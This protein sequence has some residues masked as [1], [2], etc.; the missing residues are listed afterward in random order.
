MA[1]GGGSFTTENNDLPGTY[2]NFVSAVSAS[3]ALSDRGVATMPLELDWGVEGEVFEVTNEDFQKRS[4]KIFGYPVDN[5]KMKGLFDLFMGA[6]TLY[7][8]R[9]NGG[10]KKAENTFATALYSGIRGNDLKIAI[11]QNVD[12]PALFDVITYLGTVLV[13]SQTV[14]DVTGL[15]ANDYVTF[16]T[17]ATLAVTAATPLTDGTNGVVDGAAHQ[18]YL[19]R[20]ESYSYNIMGVVVMEEPTKKLYASFVKRLRDKMGIK[21]QLVAYRLAADYLGVISVEN[22]ATGDGVPEASLVYWV[23]GAEA[24]CAVNKTCQNKVYNGSFSIDTAYTQNQLKAA[25]KAGKFILHKVN[26]DIRVL[27]DI[28]TMVTTSDTC[29]DVFKDNQTIRVIDQI[30]NDDATMFNTKYLGEVPNDAAGRISLWSDLKKIRE[31]LQTIR[32]IENFTDAD[33]TVV[34]GETKKSVRVTS[35]INVVNAMGQ[36]YMTVVVA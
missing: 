30:G 3:V 31:D 14:A 4:M 35:T 36:L 33:V 22:K 7:A 26:S 6:S 20:I 18:A 17:D 12:D 11:Q 10:G 32:A 8:Y 24:G 27:E 9:L 13:D 21:F 2:I 1:L 15:V 28:N 25:K 19:D 23:T 5:A 29:G 16:K 34:Q